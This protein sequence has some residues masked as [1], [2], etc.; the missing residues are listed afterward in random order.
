MSSNH[1]RDAVYKLATVDAPF[2]DRV[3]LAL[4]D[5]V[6]FT[7]ETSLPPDARKVFE[8]IKAQINATGLDDRITRIVH[9]LTRPEL[10]QL[11]AKLVQLYELANAAI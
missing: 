11:A 4:A 1:L 10:S 7:G 2:Q 5:F 9:E 3:E 8:D 6:A